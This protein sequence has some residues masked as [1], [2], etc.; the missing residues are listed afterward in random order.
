MQTEEELRIQDELQITQE[1]IAE[2]RF[3]KGC[4]IV[5]AQKAPDKFT[6]LTEGFPVIDWV[7]QTPLPAG[8][9][10]CDANGN[11]AII[12]RRNGKPVVGKT[13]YTGNQELINKAKKKANAQY[14]VPNVE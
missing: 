7:R 14:R 11:T 5:V 2:S 3:K 1:K 6:S 9:V 4:V 8:T 10:V 13:A 12:E